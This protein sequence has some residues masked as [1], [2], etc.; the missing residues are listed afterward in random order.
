MHRWRL[1]EGNANRERLESEGPVKKYIAEAFGTFVL[2]FVGV[3]S[4]VAGGFGGALPLGQIGIGLSF[5]LAVTAMA[6]AIG[7]VSGAHLNPAVTLGVFLAGRMPARDVAPYMVAQVIGAV[8]GSLFIY[9]AALGRAKGYDISASGLGQNAWDPAEGFGLGAAFLIEVL[10]TFVFVTVILNVTHPLHETV[11]AGLVI[12]LTLA[13]LHFAFIPVSG[14]SLNPARSL[15]PA[16]F[17][18]GTA[19]RELWLYIIGPLIGGALAGA[20]ARSGLLLRQVSTDRD[21]V[22]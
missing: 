9:L 17:V 11:F 16:L 13:I 5:G 3:G 7:P 22:R 6:Y 2:V 14:N 8:L 1:Q 21:S 20:V 19:I 15:G 12:G 4:I 18:G 10:A